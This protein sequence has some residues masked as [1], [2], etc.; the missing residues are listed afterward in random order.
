[1]LVSMDLIILILV[2]LL[3]FATMFVGAISG[4]VGLVTR[5]ALLFLGFPAQSVIAASRVAGVP[6]D[7]L[8][9]FILHKN[10]KV[11][12]TVAYFLM[13]PSLI[14]AILAGLFVVATYESLD[15][16]LGVMLLGCAL[17]YIFNK[18]FGVKKANSKIPVFLRHTVAFFG[19]ILLSFFGTITGGLGPLY[20]TFYMWL[21]GKSYIEASGVWRAGAFIGNL[22]SVAVLLFSGILDWTLTACLAAGFVLGSYFGTHYH[23][24]KGEEWVRGIV[25]IVTVAGAIKLLFF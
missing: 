22:G 16:V 14:G 1:M 12:W 3:A 20:S 10:K 9:L 6:A 7:S 15:V 8:T 11:E 2:F 13:I 25:I 19:T 21:Y 24:K 17:I 18:S 5:P 23:L 4:G